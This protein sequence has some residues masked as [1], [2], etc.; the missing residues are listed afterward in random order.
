MICFL[1]TNFDI[2]VAM[3]FLTTEYKIWSHTQTSIELQSL[4]ILPSYQT[5]I[6]K[7]LRVIDR[8]RNQPQF[9]MLYCIKTFCEL[10]CLPYKV[11]L[12][13]YFILVC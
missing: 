6:A 10:L 7:W 3:Q 11:N 9:S 12:R 2:Q 13:P 4:D 5:P 8:K 1:T